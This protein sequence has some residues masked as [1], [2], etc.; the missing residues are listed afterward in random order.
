[1]SKIKLLTAAVVGLLIVNLGLLAFLLMSKPMRPP[2]R[3]GPGPGKEGP[4]MLIIKRLDFDKDQVTAY[5]QLIGRHQELVEELNR[6]TGDTKNN[7]YSTLADENQSKKDSLISRLGDLQEQIEQ[8]HYNHFTDLRG[9][10]RPEQR[11]QFQ[12][13]TQELAGYFGGPKNTP[14]HR[15]K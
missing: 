3:G 10:C 5:E 6:E 15:Q 9:L 11:E 7:L 8:V 4:K 12:A 2:G 1:M 13:L 14:P